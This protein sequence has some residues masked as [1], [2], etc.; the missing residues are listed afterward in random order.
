MKSWKIVD[1]KYILK[2]SVLHVRRDDCKMTDGRMAKNYYV[3]EKSDYCIIA[4]LTANPRPKL[5][6]V[7]QYRHPIKRIDIEFP[8]GFVK[9][10]EPL[11]VA[12]QRELLEETG[13]KVKKLKYVGGFY[14]SPGIL[15]NKAHIFI[16]F[17][18]IKT[19]KQKLDRHEQINVKLLIMTEALQAAK[20]GKIKDLGTNLAL[21]FI[22]DL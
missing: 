5:I 1:S 9:N 12:A 10:Q 15:T 17:D 14:A 6:M 22:K 13:Y 8:A 20:K 3:I 2:N 11:A 7:E 21:A 16:G 18:A 19:T 4:A